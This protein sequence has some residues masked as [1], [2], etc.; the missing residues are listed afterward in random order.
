MYEESEKNKDIVAGLIC[1]LLG[2]LL[3]VTKFLW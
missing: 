2:S 3:L 1:C